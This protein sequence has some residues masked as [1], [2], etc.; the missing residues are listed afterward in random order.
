[1]KMIIFRTSKIVFL[2]AII[3]ATLIGCFNKMSET[4]RDESA[5]INGSFEVTK[6]GL[7]VNW[8][9]YASTT[10]PTGN[11][12][13]I[14]D[15]TDYKDG[16]QSLKFLVHECSPKGGWLSPGI[17]QEYSANSGETYKVSFWVKNEGSEFRVKIGGVSAFEGQYDTVVESRASIHDWKMFEYDYKMPMEF[18]TI[19]FEL[20][21][22]KPGSFWID[23]IKIE[24]INDKDKII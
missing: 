24:V 2:L 23:D 14:I 11:Y 5:G 19:R 21:V 16:K 6:S 7:P 9:I 3:A 12:E 1:M 10:I 22:L 8:T 15:T 17:S 4:V 18:E 20:N 13:L